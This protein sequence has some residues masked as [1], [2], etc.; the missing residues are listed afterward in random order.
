MVEKLGG[1]IEQLRKE[2]GLSQEELSNA[3]RINRVSLS[4]IENNERKITVTELQSL[5]K[6][7][8]ISV[9]EI[10]NPELRPRIS[11]KLETKKN[12]RKHSDIRISIPEK[13]M[14]KFEQVLLYI[15]N[16]VGSKPNVGE[17]IIY[18]LLY[19][20]DFDFYE[21]YEEQLIGATYQKNTHGPTPKEFITIVER[22]IEEK[23]IIK[24]KHKYF[25]YEQKKYLPLEKYDLSIFTANEIELIDEVLLKY[26]DKSAKELSEYSH[27]DV[28]WLSTKAGEDINYESVFYRTPE[29][30]VRKY[31]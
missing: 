22:M 28:P 11:I 14:G 27:G 2:H 9:D 5:S 16:K 7:F 1:R 25:R 17:T 10:L 30:S 23:K 29:Y 6:I 24:I 26:S 3:I 13:N 18:K 19:F 4:K 8:N 21:K 20:I 12:L 15:L 31:E